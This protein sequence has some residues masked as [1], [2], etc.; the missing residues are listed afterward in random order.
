MVV[1]LVRPPPHDPAGM[2]PLTVR[3][4]HRPPA[5]TWALSSGTQR[6]PA[7]TIF[8]SRSEGAVRFARVYVRGDVCYVLLRQSIRALDAVFAHPLGS[9]SLFFRGLERLI[10]R[11]FQVGRDGRGV[12]LDQQHTWAA[13]RQQHE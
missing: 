8:A 2:C 3:A 11:L 10:R 5:Y 6:R 7:A 12:G 4:V 1:R 9:F 13:N